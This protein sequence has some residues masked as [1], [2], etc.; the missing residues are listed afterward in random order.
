MKITRFARFRQ[1]AERNKQILNLAN[2]LMKDI[3]IYCEGRNYTEEV[4]QRQRI[5]L[6]SLC[7]QLEALFL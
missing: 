5:L 6:S 4:K 1:N 2:S 3:R 7:V